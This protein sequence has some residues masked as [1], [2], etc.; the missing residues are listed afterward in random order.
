MQKKESYISFLFLTLSVKAPTSSMHWEPRSTTVRLLILGIFSQIVRLCNSR[1]VLGKSR[2]H[3]K[4]VGSRWT[5]NLLMSKMLRNWTILEVIQTWLS[6][7]L[8]GFEFDVLHKSQHLWWKSS[9]NKSKEPAF[10]I[11]LAVVRWWPPSGENKSQRLPA[12]EHTLLLH[13]HDCAFKWCFFFCFFFFTLLKF[14]P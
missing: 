9:F 5:N 12:R 8:K 11:D 10:S 6:N 1:K 3:Q 14:V 7:L 2:L 4:D 13:Q